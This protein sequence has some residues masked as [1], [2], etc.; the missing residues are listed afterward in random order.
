MI[1]K[2]F[3]IPNLWLT[4]AFRSDASDDIAIFKEGSFFYQKE[5]TGFTGWLQSKAFIFDSALVNLNE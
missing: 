1:K 5:R 3:E 2:Y 4:L